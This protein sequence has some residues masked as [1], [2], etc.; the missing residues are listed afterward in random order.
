LAGSIDRLEAERRALLQG[1]APE[2]RLRLSGVRQFE[3]ALEPERWLE[4]ELTLSWTPIARGVRAARRSELA[5][6]KEALR[7]RYV[8]AL[9]AG[10]VQVARVKN[11]IMAALQRTSVKEQNVEQMQQLLDETRKLYQAGRVP[12][13]DFVA[14]EARLQQARVDRAL[15]RLDAVEAAARLTQITGKQLQS[16]M[17]LLVEVE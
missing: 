13:S 3:T 10:K 9:A 17:P 1:G 11:D 5:E 16:E 6:R 14:A 4:G 7:Q 2:L 8:N 15:A 12:L